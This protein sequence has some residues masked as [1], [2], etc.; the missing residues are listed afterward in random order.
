MEQQVD[1]LIEQATDPNYTGKG[2]SWMGSM[3]VITV[4][5]NYSVEQQV[6]CLIEQATDPNIL[7][8]VYL[9]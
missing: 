8:R 2:L 5:G 6:D 7:G 9:G 4:S 1:C 3:D